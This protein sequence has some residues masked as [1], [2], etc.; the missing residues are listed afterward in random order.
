ML[1]HQCTLDPEVNE[2]SGLLYLDGKFWT[3][4]DSGGEAALYCMDEDGRLL[5]KLVVENASNVDWEDVAGDSL[6][7][8]V[9]DV[10]N[11]FASRDTL[12]IYRIPLE[13]L[14]SSVGNSGVSYTTHEGII[15][16]SYSEKPEQTSRGWS[17]LDCEALL[18][19]GDSLYLFSKN[20]VDQSTSVF[21]LP[22]DPG[23]YWLS[24]CTTYPA[25]LLVTGA[26]LD[27]VNNKVSL[28]GYRQY[29]P[30]VLSYGFSASP[31]VLDC[32]GRARIYPLRV[33]RQVEGICYD[34]KGKLYIS[35]E[36]SLKKQSLFRLGTSLH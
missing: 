19:W 21:V 14:R 23:H 20:W 34:T 29:M 36:R 32:G 31:A 12:S 15:E 22:K 3:F 26:D 11:N 2:T 9:A 25:R 6:W 4:N 13:A 7:V 28:V 18:S 5:H 1:V 24:S 8:Y 16:L 33:G 27:P 17:S 10:G 30:V 35:S